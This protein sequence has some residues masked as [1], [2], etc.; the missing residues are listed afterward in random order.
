MKADLRS[1]QFKDR[2][3][4]RIT[5]FDKTG[6]IG[7]VQQAKVPINKHTIGSRPLDSRQTQASSYL[8]SLANS[9]QMGRLASNIT[10]ESFMSPV[11]PERHHAYSDRQQSNFS[12]YSKRSN[13][14]AA[15]KPTCYDIDSMRSSYH[16]D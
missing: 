7:M 10:S 8:Q 15:N 13:W 12:M 1:T 11:T 3:H 5:K 9:S 16:R 2:F 6:H 4:G 14:A